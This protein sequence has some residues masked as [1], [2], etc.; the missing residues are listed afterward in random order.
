[1][2]QHVVITVR[3]T[4]ILLVG[5]QNH[6][7]QVVGRQNHLDQ[8][9]LMIQTHRLVQAAHQRH[10]LQATQTMKRGLMSSQKFHQMVIMPMPTEDHQALHCQF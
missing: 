6:L 3:Q 9:R 5:R 2:L 10:P 4:G 1:M 8:A 7:D